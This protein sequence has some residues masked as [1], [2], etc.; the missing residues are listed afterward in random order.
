MRERGTSVCWETWVGSL[1]QLQE[2]H[3]T[4]CQP[5]GDETDNQL[6]GSS[7][8]WIQLPKEPICNL[9][10]KN[11]PTQD[12]YFSYSCQYNH[13]SWQGAGRN[14]SSF[15]WGGGFVSV[16]YLA[17]VLVNTAVFLHL[18][19]ATG[20][21]DLKILAIT[22]DSLDSHRQPPAFTRH[23]WTQSPGIKGQ[24]H[25]IVHISYWPG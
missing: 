4:L 23:S 6:A 8:V 12:S 7:T 9:F 1:V 19:S 2:L 20:A 3:S 22:V 17:I 15:L 10:I 21:M 18:V 24:S 25:Q 5:I 14:L 16:L 11:M 13:I